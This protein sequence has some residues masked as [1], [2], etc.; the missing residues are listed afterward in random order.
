MSSTATGCRRAQMEG[1]VG[2]A[3]YR[4]DRQR[5]R[6]H[7]PITS[8]PNRWGGSGECIVASPAHGWNN[9]SPFTTQTYRNSPPPHG[10][11][12]PCVVLN[13]SV[14]AGGTRQSFSGSVCAPVVGNSMNSSLVCMFIPSTPSRLTACLARAKCRHGI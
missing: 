13:N 12:Q 9:G 11:P 10:H 1:Q 2:I 8:A 5:Q 6:H 3:V 14:A 7:P 4:W